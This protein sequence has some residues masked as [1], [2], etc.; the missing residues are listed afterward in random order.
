MFDGKNEKFKLF[1]DLFH[2]ILKM[3]PEVNETKKINLFY[4]YLRKEALQTFRN[5]NATN[6]RALEDVLIIFPRKSVKLE[7]PS[8]AEFKWHKLTFNPNTKSLSEFLE[9]LSGYAEQALGDQAQQMMDSFLYD[10]MP[11]HLKRSINLAYLENGTY[12]QII[13]HLGKELE[14]SDIENDGELPVPTVTVAVTM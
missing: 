3:Q 4:A 9:E 6:K 5:I 10:K 14:L 1:E 8:T 2:T 11:A 12:D 13:A 7:S